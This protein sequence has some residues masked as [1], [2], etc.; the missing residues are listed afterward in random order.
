VR[1]VVGL[2]T[3]PSLSRG[4]SLPAILSA[5]ALAKVEALAKAGLS[6]LWPLFSSRPEGPGYPLRS[7]G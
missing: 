3:L 6:S 4:T 7:S 5:I 2:P 1:A